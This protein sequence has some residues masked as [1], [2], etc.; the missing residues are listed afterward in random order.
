MVVIGRGNEK[1]FMVQVVEFREL[2]LGEQQTVLL[3]G[4]NFLKLKKN[5]MVAC[6]KA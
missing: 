5:K 6:E 1:V 3:H 2:K 4:N